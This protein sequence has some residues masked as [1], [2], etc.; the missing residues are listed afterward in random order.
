MGRPRHDVSPV[1][2]DALERAAQTERA[3][4]SH[5]DRSLEEL[6]Q[7][8]RQASENGASLRAIAAI[9]SRSHGR[10]RE[11]LRGAR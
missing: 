10:V 1:D 5:W 2:R 7:A 6:Q 3:A 4:R 11:I 8:I 9:V